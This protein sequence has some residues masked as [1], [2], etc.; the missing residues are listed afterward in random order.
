LSSTNE[1]KT[2]SQLEAEIG[3][4]P[5]IARAWKIL[6][7]RLLPED[8][9][10]IRHRLDNIL[11]QVVSAAEENGILAGYAKARDHVRELRDQK[12]ERAEQVLE[13]YEI[14]D[15]VVAEPLLHPD[16]MDS[17]AEMHSLADR[18]IFAEYRAIW[19]CLSFLEDM[20]DEW[21][22]DMTMNIAYRA[23]GA[24]I[25]KSGTEFANRGHTMPQVNISGTTMDSEEM[26]GIVEVLVD[27]GFSVRDAINRVLFD[28]THKPS[29]PNWKHKGSIWA[30]KYKDDA[31]YDMSDVR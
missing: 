15:G 13:Q 21:Q 16:I 5:A 20:C 26:I 25:T 10:D 23:T 4:H 12:L 29:G 1:S 9:A 31:P 19:G 27:N 24:M 17:H 18:T 6:E 28:E 14:W 30:R 8:F 11:P 22:P 2:F 3:D 7:E